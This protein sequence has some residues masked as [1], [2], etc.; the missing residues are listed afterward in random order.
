VGDSL[1]PAVPKNLFVTGTPGVGKT[2]L[3]KECVLPFRESVG[4]FFTE[5]IR[6]NRERRGFLLKTF[7]GESGILA[8]KGRKGKFK[9]NKYGVDINV[10]DD[11]GVAALQVAEKE[12][13]VVVV[14]EIGTM[15]MLS[16]K[17]CAAI[18]QLLKGSK[19]VLATIRQKAEPFTSQIKKMG[20][21]KLIS[22]NRDNF[23]VV[24]NEVR[25]WVEIQCQK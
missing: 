15:E 16:Q 14:D 18:A 13:A 24:K 25:R 4:G 3:I 6:E 9:V 20:E 17:F 11:L 22:L 7:S 1:T 23:P 5:E 12:K 2:T 21:T 19:P 10:L 8:E